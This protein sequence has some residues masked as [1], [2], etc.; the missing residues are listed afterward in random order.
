MGATAQADYFDD[1]MKQIK[2]MPAK[3]LDLSRFKVGDRIRYLRDNLIHIPC[4]ECKQKDW[5]HHN[6]QNHER[7]ETRNMRGL[8]GVV[9]KINQG[10]AR[11]W[12]PRHV[13]D[14]DG[15]HWLTQRPGWLTVQFEISSYRN[16]DGSFGPVGLGADDEGSTWEAA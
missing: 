11:F 6:G 14:D 4:D 7:C 15:W 1:E 13:L 9:T 3:W 5:F 16:P 8:V 2:R 12:P 10:D